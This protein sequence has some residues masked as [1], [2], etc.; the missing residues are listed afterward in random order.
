[1][2]DSA[3]P[4]ADRLAALEETL[5][6]AKAR[7]AAAANRRRARARWQVSVEAARPLLDY[8]EAV[9]F[10][11]REPDEAEHRRLMREVFENAEEDGLLLTVD[12]RGALR[13]V[14]P[15]V[16]REE[17]E[18]GKALVE[19]R[20]ERD[21]F[22]AEN[23]EGLEAERRAV[24]SARLKSAVAKGDADAMREV[25]GARPPRPPENTLTSG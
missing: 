23:A 19:A 17:A 8:V 22:A 15:A 2:T 6:E 16:D 1:M 9:Y 4:L 24:E 18:A 12:R 11:K 7:R 13:F 20:E 5:S 21:R 14:D 3:T 25:L 10:K